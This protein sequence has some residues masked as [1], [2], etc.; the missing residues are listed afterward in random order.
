[1]L[2][3][4]KSKYLLQGIF[5]Y[6]KDKRKLKLI[7]YNKLFQNKLNIN[8]EDY[9]SYIS[10]REFNIKYN[11]NFDNICIE[12]I[13]LNLRHTGKEIFE[14]L[15]KIKFKGLTKLYLSRNDIKNINLLE[16]ANFQELKELYLSGNEI[17]D[18]TILGKVN[19]DN[20]EILDLNHNKISD[21]TILEKAHLKNLKEL[22]FSDNDI[23]NIN[24]LEKIDFE[25][26]NKLNLSYN[27]ISDINVFGKVNLKNLN[28]LDLVGNKI[29][30]YLLINMLKSKIKNFYFKNKE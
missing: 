4:I 2:T 6:M 7:K 25:K 24:S 9:E 5:D 17:S 12:E 22:Y 21:I 15:N 23:S 10:L 30:N 3:E 28:E 18:I 13:N 20:L 16:R 27:Y 19:L 14:Y 8:K 29:D 11:L 1:M 26:L